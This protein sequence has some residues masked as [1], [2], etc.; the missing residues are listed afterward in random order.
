M[1]DNEIIGSALRTIAGFKVD[2]AELSV[3]TICTT[4]D[5]GEGHYLGDSE[6][7]ARMKS[8]FFYPAVADRSGLNDWLDSG[9]VSFEETAEA[10]AQDILAKHFPDHI[11]AETDT[12]IRN[13]LNIVLPAERCAPPVTEEDA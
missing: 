3:E 9:A 11:G 13:A 2:E 5:G 7:L 1:I 6:T 10:I 8:G 12:A 4:C